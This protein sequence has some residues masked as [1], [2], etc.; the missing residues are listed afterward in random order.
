MRLNDSSAPL[1]I[2]GSELVFLYESSVSN[3]LII[4]YYLKYSLCVYWIGDYLFVHTCESC[5]LV[6]PH[7]NLSLLSYSLLNF[8]RLVIFITSSLSLY[9]M[10]SVLN[11]FSFFGSSL[12]Q[13][14]LMPSSC[15]VPLHF[16]ELFITTSWNLWRNLK[17]VIMSP[18][19]LLSS[20][21][22]ISTWSKHSAS[23]IHRTH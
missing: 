9:Y 12:A 10:F 13:L 6:G 1:Y 19:F 7:L 16:M 3:I 18:V 2:S 22:G 23:I 4:S 5:T 11:Y 21:M 17:V 15:F 20:K 14:T 8:V